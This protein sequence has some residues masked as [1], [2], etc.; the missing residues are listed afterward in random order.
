MYAHLGY[1]LGI[2]TRVLMSSVIYQKVS[3]TIMIII[4]NYLLLQII[5]L[6]QIVIGQVTIG[7][8]V[9]LASNDIHKFETVSVIFNKL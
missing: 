5:S 1:H 9:N 3:I 8:I 2:L 4:M 7:H 6:S